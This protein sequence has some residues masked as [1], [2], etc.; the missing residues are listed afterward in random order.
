[1]E[2]YYLLNTN[3]DKPLVIRFS[4][5]T[6]WFDNFQPDGTCTMHVPL[7]Y[8]TSRGLKIGAFF[9]YDIEEENE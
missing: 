5:D 2:N 7:K 3:I 6:I 8:L 9:N 1:M 4:T